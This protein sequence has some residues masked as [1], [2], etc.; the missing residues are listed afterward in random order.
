MNFETDTDT[1]PAGTH[2]LSELAAL[3][4]DI[5]LD[6]DA[7]MAGLLG[8]G[9]QGRAFFDDVGTKAG[10]PDGPDGPA[11]AA[12]DLSSVTGCHF[13]WE[14]TH[15]CPDGGAYA[16]V[17]DARYEDRS[18]AAT[19]HPRR[20]G[21]CRRVPGHGEGS[22]DA[23]TNPDADAGQRLREP[24][25]CREPGD[26][27]DS[28]QTGELDDPDQLIHEEQITPTYINMMFNATSMIPLANVGRMLKDEPIEHVADEYDTGCGH[29]DGDRTARYSNDF[30]PCIPVVDFYAM[31]PKI[32]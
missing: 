18:Y 21:R 4:G 19:R 26:E 15:A 20:N 14:G 30:G 23:E 3:R 9:A 25:H 17:E 32:G 13:L 12:G 7:F 16:D 29:R 22:A 24:Q 1:G 2:L 31:N 11:G 8:D 6:E 5:P 28:V 27:T 10:G